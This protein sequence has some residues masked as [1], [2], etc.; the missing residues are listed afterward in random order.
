METAAIIPGAGDGI[1]RASGMSANDSWNAKKQA[2]F[3]RS[4]EARR[5]V[6]CSP[7]RAQRTLGTRPPKGSSP[8]GAPCIEAPLTGLA[9][10][11]VS[12]SQGLPPCLRQAG[13]TLGY[14]RRPL[15]GLKAGFACAI[16]GGHFAASR[17]ASPARFKAATSRPQGRLRLRD[18]RRPLRSL[19]AT[20]LLV[21]RL[22]S[23]ANPTESARYAEPALP[24]CAGPRAARRRPPTGSPPGWRRR[25][26]PRGC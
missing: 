21:V 8:A 16:Q 12:R 9:C 18:S 1:K 2:G 17:P 22:S 3:L 19:K 10:Q 26:R 23:D 13:F 5:A 24:C 25:R 11:R 4:A 15:R 20:I 7:W 6:F 14:K